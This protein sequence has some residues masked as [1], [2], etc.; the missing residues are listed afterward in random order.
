MLHKYL[1][2][3]TQVN[4]EYAN[5]HTGNPF[6]SWFDIVGV[7]ACNI[8]STALVSFF[9]EEEMYFLKNI[10]LMIHRAVYIARYAK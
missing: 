1:A 4:V 6:V 8:N 3:I 2:H 9:E 10:G 5:F 7:Y